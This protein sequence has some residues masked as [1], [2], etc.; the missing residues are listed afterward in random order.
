[1]PSTV[2]PKASQPTANVVVLLDAS[3]SMR[4]KLDGKVKIDLAKEAIQKFVSK[5]PQGVRVSLKVYGH[6]G[7]GSNRDKAVSCGS[8]ETVYP[9]GPYNASKFQA[10]LN[11][12]QPSGWTP[13]A[14]AIED[15]AKDFGQ[16]TNPDVK[17]VIYVVSDG[18]ETCDGDPIQAAQRLNQSHIQAVVNIIGFDVKDEEQKALKEIAVAGKGEYVRVDTPDQLRRELER[19]SMQKWI[20]WNQWGNRTWVMIQY[21]WQDKFSLI[22]RHYQDLKIKSNRES[23]RLND[24]ARYLNQLNKLSDQELFKLQQMIHARSQTIQNHYHDVYVNKSNLLKRIRDQLQE[25]VRKKKEEMQNQYRQA[26]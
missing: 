24:S 9:L 10:A 12:F 5:L 13:L 1:M 15:S 19:E 14:K 25:D 18:K 26:N 20:A 16:Q 3:G 7:S 8:I 2:D 21:E 23:S 17:N 11:R 6:K 22:H 4:G